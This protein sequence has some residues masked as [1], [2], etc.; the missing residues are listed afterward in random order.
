MCNNLSWRI[1]GGLDDIEILHTQR[2]Y[3]KYYTYGTRGWKPEHWQVIELFM[4]TQL[5]VVQI[6]LHLEDHVHAAVWTNGKFTLLYQNPRPAISKRHERYRNRGER[7][8]FSIRFITSKVTHLTPG[9]APETGWL[10][11][12]HTQLRIT[13]SSHEHTFETFTMAQ[14]SP[15]VETHKYVCCPRNLYPGNGTR[16]RI[17]I[18]HWVSQICGR[19]F[20]LNA[21]YQYK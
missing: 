9:R 17:T 21:T 20:R 2:D 10:Q 3:W 4:Y 1:L 12:V 11:T 16:A 8:S 15:S 7:Q 6:H 18:S 13:K 19:L 5:H 14:V